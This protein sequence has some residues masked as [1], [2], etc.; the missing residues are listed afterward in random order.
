MYI[1]CHN[2]T[3][4][5]LIHADADFA[6]GSSDLHI[7]LPKIRS[8]RDPG[9]L[10]FAAWSDP[11]FEGKHAL[12]NAVGMLREIRSLAE[13]NPDH[14]EVALTV[15]DV[16]SI[17]G[18]NKVAILLA[19]EG[20][21]PI[22][23]RL[24]NLQVLFDEGVRLITF[25]HLVSPDWAGGCN[26]EEPRGL[27]GLGREIVE[28]MNELGMV[29]D[30]A[31]ASEMTIED[32][33][34]TSRA[35]IVSSHSCVKEVFDTSR[36]LSDRSIK[37]IADSGGVVAIMF[38]P[39]VLVPRPKDNGDPVQN[40]G[41]LFTEVDNDDSLSIEEKAKRKFNLITEIL[42]PPSRVPTLDV[43]FEHIDYVVDLVGDDHAAIGSD[44]DGIP[45]S[46]AGLEDLGKLDSLVEVMRRNG[47]SDSRIKKIMAGNVLRVMRDTLG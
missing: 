23:N 27:S 14:L 44:F 22:N 33:A 26:D 47:Y 41:E 28:R 6:G 13:Q 31:H 2:D 18:K 40:I 30:L 35:P 9:A 39:D 20:G 32:A 5:K 24:A 11:V 1:D 8:L 29:V 42:K 38:F 45:Y 17:A 21:Q 34:A 37:T 7:D 43:V 25:C 36:A 10:F 16:E 19:V 3:I 15:D 12:E 4:L 46:C